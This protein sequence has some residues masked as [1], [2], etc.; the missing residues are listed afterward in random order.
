MKNCK[1]LSGNP[2]IR[3][4][5]CPSPGSPDPRIPGSPDHRISRL[6]ILR[7]FPGNRQRQHTHGPGSGIFEHARRFGGGRPGRQQIV[8]EQYVFVSEVFKF[9]YCKSALYICPALFFVQKALGG[10]VADTPQMVLSHGN[11][12]FFGQFPGQ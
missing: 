9:S 4:S 2:V 7:P 1:W 5:G 8:D 3:I 11:R 6:S 10:G 12:E